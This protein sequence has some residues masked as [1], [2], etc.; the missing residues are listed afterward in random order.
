MRIEESLKSEVCNRID[1]SNAIF[2]NNKRNEGK[3]RLHYDLIKYMKMGIYNILEDI[4]KHFTLVKLMD[5]LGN[6]NHAIIF[7][8]KWIFDSNYEKSLVLNRASLD[9]IFAPS[10]GEEQAGKF[11][12]VFNAVIC[13]YSPA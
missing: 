10:V 6:V 5:S 9:M 1:F 4:S 11:E 12:S 2:K 13:I 8:G 3:S 7:V